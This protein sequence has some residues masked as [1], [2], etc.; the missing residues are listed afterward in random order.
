MS[1]AN[2]KQ[3]GLAPGGL[4]AADRSKEDAGRRG[5]VRRIIQVIANAAAP[6]CVSAFA[7][8]INRFDPGPSGARL[9]LAFH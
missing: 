2:P 3:T 9:V 4:T 1:A 8:A 5:K 6:L 7:R